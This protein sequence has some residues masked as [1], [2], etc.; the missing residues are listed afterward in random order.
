[1]SVVTPSLNQGQFIREAIESVLAQVEPGEVEHIV[2]DGGSTDG[3]HDVLSA[4]PHLTV[5]RDPGL[6]QSHAVNLGLRAAHGEV[7]GW[8]NADDRYLPGAFAGAGGALADHSEAGIVYS[9]VR[10]IDE[11]GTPIDDLRPGPF[12]LDR[13]LNGAN[14]IPQPTVFIRAAL[15]KEVGLLNESLHYVMDY[16]LWLRASRLTR[17]LWVDE[18]WAEFR[19]H[20]SSKTVSRAYAFWPEKRAVARA[21][22]G[23]FFSDEWR[24]RTLNRTY[25]KTV[26]ASLR[27]RELRRRPKIQV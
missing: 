7:I 2:V 9:N 15:L 25:P 11:A 6:G 23:P 16:E 14:A 1:M 12:D 5:L 10:F 21:Y 24:L 18:T 17:L 19:R 8:L 26:L 22:G 4:Y 13:L 20:S 27:R 3:T